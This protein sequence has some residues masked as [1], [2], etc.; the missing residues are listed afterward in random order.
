MIELLLCFWS[1]WL[2]SIQS[3]SILLML[4]LLTMQIHLHFDRIESLSVLSQCCDQSVLCTD[5]CRSSSLS[6]FSHSFCYFSS[7][8]DTYLSTTRER[9]TRLF[10]H[11][12]ACCSAVRVLSTGIHWIKISSG[13]LNGVFDHCS[14]R[15]TFLFN[16]RHA[17]IFVSLKHLAQQR[18]VCSQMPLISNKRNE[19]EERHWSLMIRHST[20]DDSREKNRGYEGRWPLHAILLVQC[21]S[22]DYQERAKRCVCEKIKRGKGKIFLEEVNDVQQARHEEYWLIVDRSPFTACD[23]IVLC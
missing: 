18:S 10:V 9:T 12:H 1:C 7:A 15:R 3:V 19:F 4:L 21:Q 5:M 13:R 11:P 17:G 20:L 23:S 14:F 8:L 22:S 6:W 16:R 2:Q